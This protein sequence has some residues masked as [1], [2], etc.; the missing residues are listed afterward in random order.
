MKRS[1][2]LTRL[3]EFQ[4]EHG[5]ISDNAISEISQKLHVSKIEIEGVISFYHFFHRQP[6]GKYI[7]YLN[8]SIISEFKGFAEV[9]S[10]VSLNLLQH[11]YRE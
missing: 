4:D 2:L 3:W 6:T 9:K 10:P 1:R 11:V 8:N 5:F 7:I